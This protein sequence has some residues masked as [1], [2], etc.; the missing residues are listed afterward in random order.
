M[1]SFFRRRWIR[2]TL[3]SVLVAFFLAAAVYLTV[4]R[5]WHLH[6]GATEEEVNRL[7][8]GDSLISD[9]SLNTTRAITIRARPEQIW[10]WL[11]QMGP[12]RG[13]WYS[14]DALDNGGRPSADRIFPEWQVTLRPGDSLGIGSGPK[15]QVMKVEANRYLVLGPKISWVLALYQQADSTTRLVERLR[16]YY[17]WSSFRGA[18]FAVCLDVGDFIMMRKMLLTLKERVECNLVER[19]D[20]IR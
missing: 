2:R 16:S 14:Y 19:K 18:M 9:A 12:G 15:F 8:P 10:P 17:D 1:F 20:Q 13:G 7:M 6:W 5:P 3:V 11:V 4:I